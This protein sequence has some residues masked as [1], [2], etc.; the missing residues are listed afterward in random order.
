V[1]AGASSGGELG[2]IHAAPCGPALRAGSSARLQ[3]P[4][5]SAST[6]AVAERPR[7]LRGIGAGGTRRPGRG[8]LMP[9][10]PGQAAGVTNRGGCVRTV[11]IGLGAEVGAAWSPLVTDLAGN[12][13]SVD[14]NGRW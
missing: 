13:G 11:G 14:T 3:A 5:A 6:R 4:T 10:R 1:R 12:R 7:V 2:G 8:L 9:A